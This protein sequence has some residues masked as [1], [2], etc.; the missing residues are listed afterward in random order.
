MELKFV[1]IKKNEN[2]TIENYILHKK[3]QQDKK[4]AF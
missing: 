4:S 3:K 2:K 1:M